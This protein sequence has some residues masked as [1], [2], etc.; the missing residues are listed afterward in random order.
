MLPLYY[1]KENKETYFV[2]SV[3]DNLGFK[4]AKVATQ[5]INPQKA[6]VI[7]SA[8][9]SNKIT[10]IEAG[11]GAVLRIKDKAAVFG[12]DVIEELSDVVRSEGMQR[13][14]ADDSA[15]T[16]NNIMFLNSGIPA[17]NINIPVKHYG[18]CYEAVCFEDI[19]ALVESII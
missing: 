5:E 12:K 10:K 8:D 1:K 11:K 16:N 18:S 17:V 4:G 19:K 15:I 2:F 14:I 6:V 3:Q 13:E 7:G 9:T